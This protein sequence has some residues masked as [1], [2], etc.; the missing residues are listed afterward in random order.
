MSEHT[1]IA[2]TDSTW[3]R[4]W[5]CTHV[6]EEC[7]HCYAEAM[8]VRY[9][10]AEWGNNKPRYILSEADALQPLKWDRLAANGRAGKDG[11]RWLVF[12]ED[13]GDL[14]DPSAPAKERLRVWDTISRTPHLTYQV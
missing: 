7:I 9:G 10:R 3:G 14:F 12:V 2:W 11:K 4:W 8:S 5:G 6:S 13:M 1:S